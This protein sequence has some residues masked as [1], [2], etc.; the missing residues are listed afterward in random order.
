MSSTK[1][2][3]KKRRRDAVKAHYLPVYLRIGNFDEVNLGYTEK[4]EIV[5]E[6]DRCISCRKPKCVEACPGGFDIRGVVDKLKEDDF[7]GAADIVNDFYC[8]PSSFNRVCPAFCQDACVIGKKGDP[9]QIL[10]IKRYLADNYEKPKSFYEREALTGKMIAVIGSGPAGLTAAYDLAKKGHAV[11]VFEKLDIMGGMLAVGIPEY[12]LKNELLHAEIID[13]EKLGVVFITDN[14]FG[15]DF[16]HDDLFNRGYNS[17][18]IT[19]GAHKPKFMGIPGEALDG[20]I[21]AIQFLKD[22]AIGKDPKIGNKVMVIGGGDV[23]IDAVRVAN[24][25]GSEAYIVYRRSKEEMPAT[26]EEIHETDNEGIPINFLT[27][28]IEIIGQ[29][30]KVSRVK[31]IKM[32]LGE[33]DESGRRRPVEIEGS[34]Y[35]VEVD[36]VIQAISQEPEYRKIK[37]IGFELDRWNTFDLGEGKWETNIKGV[38]AAGDAVSGPRTAIEAIDQARKA[39]IAID[40]YL[41]GKKPEEEEIIIAE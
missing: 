7:Q 40:E 37:E 20:N 30:G 4:Q 28:P 16:D 9:L 14:A 6:V 32:E 31:L 18:L 24:R 12:R 22:V 11:T 13:L 33:T 36:T 39:A 41:I 1:P 26:K 3:K 23:A 2:I 5:D 17:I 21:H 19:I 25:L 35:F 10:N 15:I 34:E 27:N 38:F 8:I 29:Q